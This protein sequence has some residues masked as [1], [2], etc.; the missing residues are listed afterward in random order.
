VNCFSWLLNVHNFNDVSQ[1]GVHTAE[2]LVPD[3]ICLEVEIAIATLKKYKSPDSDQ[4]PAEQIQAGGEK[5][6]L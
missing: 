5:L 3:P 2:R 1:M 6:C 4:I